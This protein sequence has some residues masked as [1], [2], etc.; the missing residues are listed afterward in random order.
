MLWVPVNLWVVPCQVV[1]IQRP[2]LTQ[3]DAE[4]DLG[5]KMK[6]N[7]IEEACAGLL[8]LQPKYVAAQPR[9]CSTCE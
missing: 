6:I 8:N 2:R 1:I 4:S 7:G 9:K 3:R 5:A